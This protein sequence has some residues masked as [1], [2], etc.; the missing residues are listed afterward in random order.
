MIG[1]SKRVTLYLGCCPLEGGAQFPE[2]TLDKTL[3]RGF[4][5]SGA[6]K[7]AASAV[8]GSTE[9]M[10]SLDRANLCVPCV[11]FCDA[12]LFSPII[13]CMSSPS[14]NYCTSLLLLLLLLVLP[15]VLRLMLVSVRGVIVAGVSAGVD[16]LPLLC[17]PS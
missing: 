10:L 11:S 4:E 15:L 2:F 13:F 1:G 6:R 5:S 14:W 7:R 16:C 12:K 3:L 9:S 17:G 8:D